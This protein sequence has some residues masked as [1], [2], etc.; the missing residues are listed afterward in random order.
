MHSKRS[1][2]ESRFNLRTITLLAVL[3]GG[4]YLII[5]PVGPTNV[6][7][8]F[9]NTITKISGW[10]SGDDPSI[11]TI[12]KQQDEQGQWHFSDRHTSDDR[13]TDSVSYR[14]DTNVIPALPADDITAG[15]N[16]PEQDN[17]QSAPPSTSPLLP[18]THPQKVQQLINDARN[19]EG[20]LQRRKET[21]DQT[22]DDT[23]E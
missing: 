8:H 3:G 20:L 16:H 9:R 7:T 4:A 17:G 6:T 14:S 5:S 22:I 21:M 18:F 11:T 13:S 10:L 15:S 12:Y 2:V 23:A 19:I 1:T